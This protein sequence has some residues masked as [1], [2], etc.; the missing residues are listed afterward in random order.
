MCTLADSPVRSKATKG[1]VNHRML[2]TFERLAT[3]LL[4][5][6]ATKEQADRGALY[7]TF[8]MEGYSRQEAREAVERLMPQ[9]KP[10]LCEFCQDD[11]I[12]LMREQWL[13]DK[14]VARD[15]E[16][17]AQSRADFAAWVDSP[18]AELSSQPPS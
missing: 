16:P 6:G 13:F 9:G 14:I 17:V 1:Q 18:D 2:Y 3:G 4:E 8:R 11:L 7:A 12:E 10:M 15:P 5:R